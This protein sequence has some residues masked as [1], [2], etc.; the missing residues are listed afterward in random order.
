M[1]KT[2]IS[3]IL[4]FVATFTFAQ[5]KPKTGAVKKAPATTAKKAMPASSA[6]KA[7]T[8]KNNLDSA[9]YGFGLSMSTGMKGSGLSG[10]NYDLLVKGLQDGFGGKTP[11]L[12]TEQAEQAIQTL[13]KEVTKSKFS[14][15]ITAGKTFL[16]NNRKQ[17]GVKVTPSGLQYLVLTEGTGAKPIATDTVVA[18]Y[19][20]TLID[21]KQFDSSYDRN[22]PLEI[23][24]SRVISGWTEGLL[25][26][27]VGSKYRFF[28][29]Y[30]LAYGERGAGQD[31]PPYSTLIF[32]VELL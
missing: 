7:P 26:M 20:G 5:T 11:S 10:L 12:T 21:G 30:D 16:D 25:L 1:K 6:P 13:F 4:I 15:E 3:A 31:I 24:V 32:D 14:S 19:K 2:L 27:P 9:S 22:D 23:P 28:I 18:H 8:F 17:A 29:P